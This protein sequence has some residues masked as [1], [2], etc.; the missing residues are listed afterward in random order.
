MS[1]ENEYTLIRAI[2][3]AF[4]TR[5]MSSVGFGA[6]KRQVAKTVFV[7][8]EEKAEGEIVCQS[9]NDDYLP[10]GPKRVL[11]R[12]ELLR[13]FVPEPDI[14]LNKVQPAMHELEKIVDKADDYREAGQVFSAEFEY[15]NA[16]RVDED[17]IRATFGLGLVYLERGESGN[18]EL[19]FRKLHKLEGAFQPMHK[20][21]FNEFGIKLRK[22]KLY[23]QAMQHYVRALRLAPTDEH[24]ICNIARVYYEKGR[25]GPAKVLLEKT[26]KANPGFA[27]AE[28]F[29]AH[30]LG[31]ER[32][33]AKE[34]AAAAKPRD[35]SAGQGPQLDLTPLDEG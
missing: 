9:L 14:F 29:L 21:L 18:G 34:A 15:K 25:I 6:T 12:D 20:H 32:Q 7:Y 30:L 11:T 28:K 5:A 27:V 17:H 10:A 24:L 4:S 33:A 35:D 26:L 31:L 23:N 13:D 2:K 22:N 8:V 16:L 1:A 19:V 3:G